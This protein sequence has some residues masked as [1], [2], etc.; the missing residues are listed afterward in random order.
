MGTT[1]VV[2]GVLAQLEEF[3]DV[4]VP[5]FQVGAD[6]ALA[7][8]ALVNRDGG[9]VDH[10][11]ER[12]HAL[13]F[14][15]GAFNVRTQCA[16]RGPV[17]PQAA[18]KLGQ[19]G[20][21]LDGAVDAV[22][23]VGHGGQVAAGK[24]RTQGAGVEQG[25]GG[26]HVVE[27]GEQVVEL[28]GALFLV[29]FFDGQTHG[30]THEEALRQLDAGIVVVNEVTIVQ[31]LQAQVGEL[32]ITVALD[33][34]AKAG[35]VV[36]T[37]FRAQQFQLDAFADVGG[38]GIAVQRVHLFLVGTLGH[39]QVLQCFSADL[40]HQQASGDLGVVGLHFDQGACGHHHGGVDVVDGDAVVQVLDGF[41]DDLV[42]VDVVQAFTGGADQVLK[43]AHVQRRLA[44]VFH[45]HG[46][47][48]L[49]G[50][51]RELAGLLGTFL[52]LTVTV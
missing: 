52:R 21:V 43:A 12:H 25:R 20:V 19:H 3:L 13:G 24:L 35:H 40:V 30:D 34:G 41:G 39:A 50:G 6:R 28:D 22:Q 7:F 23:V 27:A 10:F 48:H 29:L 1:T 4:H 32:Q 16:H 31:G 15:V 9:I 17:V 38:E 18:G 45:G 14:A 5:G 47:F 36:F 2:T 26:A 37:Q 33:R 8:A 51:L 46:H 49:V 44:A 11:Q 42:G